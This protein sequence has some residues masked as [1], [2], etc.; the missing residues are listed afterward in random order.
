MLSVYFEETIR[1]Q[2]EENRKLQRQTPQ[3]GQYQVEE[4]TYDPDEE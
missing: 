3:S 4:E 1:Y 2:A